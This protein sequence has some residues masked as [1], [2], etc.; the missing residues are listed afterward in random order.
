MMT[1]ETTEAAAE[2]KIWTAA[3]VDETTKAE[4]VEMM[5]STAGLATE[6]VTGEMA[7]LKV[8]ILVKS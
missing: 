6:A 3:E 5:L 1:G 8:I 4:G 7:T 2:T